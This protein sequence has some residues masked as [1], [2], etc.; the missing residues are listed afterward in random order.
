MARRHFKIPSAFVL[1]A[2]YQ[3]TFAAVVLVYCAPLVRAQGIITTI[4]GGNQ[5]QVT[6]LG[7]P[8]TNVPLGQIKG[9]AT[10]P[11]GNVYAVDSTN[12]FVIK[13]ATTGLLTVVAGNGQTVSSGNGGPAT[14]ASFQTPY[15]IAADASGNLFIAD[16]APSVKLAA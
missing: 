2:G 1:A 10:D 11:Q 3:V 14:E 9:V 6:G 7:G 4:A 5:F 16:A 13:I 15:A 8:A 12:L